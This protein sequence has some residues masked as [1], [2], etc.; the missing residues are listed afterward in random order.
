MR[1]HVEAS[2][3]FSILLSGLIV[4]FGAL[5]M[6]RVLEVQPSGPAVHVM[7]SFCVIAMVEATLRLCAQRDL[8]RIV[9]LTT[10]VEMN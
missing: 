2:V 10:V 9:A 8:K 3:E 7:A 4:K 1:A 6:A 5:G